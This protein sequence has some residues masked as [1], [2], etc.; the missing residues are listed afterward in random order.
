M[1]PYGIND[2]QTSGV[3]GVPGVAVVTTVGAPTPGPGTVSGD[4]VLQTSHQA[5]WGRVLR[6]NSVMRPTKVLSVR[7]ISSLDMTELQGS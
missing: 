3:P 7:S 4:T 1:L 5:V 2:V 6:L